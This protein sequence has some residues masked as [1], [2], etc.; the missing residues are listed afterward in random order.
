MKY[1][2]LR[3]MFFFDILKLAVAVYLID[4]EF[5]NVCIKNE[6]YPK[7]LRFLGKFILL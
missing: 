6:N 4:L 5:G 1:G 3:R 2:K 7:N